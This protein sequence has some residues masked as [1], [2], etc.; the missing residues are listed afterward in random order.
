[1]PEWLDTDS[2]SSK[3]AAMDCLFRRAKGSTLNFDSM[4]RLHIAAKRIAFFFRA[5]TIRTGFLLDQICKTGPQ[6][7]APIADGP[8]S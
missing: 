5:I 7:K 2:R 8:R 1:M 3:R 4:T 6:K